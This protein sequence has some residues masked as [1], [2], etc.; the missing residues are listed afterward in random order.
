MT[1]R[2]M[3]VAVAIDDFGTGYSSLSYLNR[4][5]VTELKIDRSFVNKICENEED[6]SLVRSIIHLGQGQRV[7]VV[8]EGVESNDQVELLMSMNCTTV[9]GYH[10]S[11]PM[12]AESLRGWLRQGEFATPMTA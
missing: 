1:L 2:Q 10:Y 5:P 6:R 12:D 7:D 11:P 9:Q 4:L 8:A 3:G